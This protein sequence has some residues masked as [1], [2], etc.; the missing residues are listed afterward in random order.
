MIPTSAELTLLR[1]HPQETQ[2]W[3]SIYQPI[4]ILSVQL[5]NATGTPGDR[6]IPYDNIFEGWYTS[7]ESG[8]TMYVGTTPGAKD[9][10]RV[11]VRSATDSTITVAENS[12]IN[13]RDD[14]FLSV[15][16]F[17]EIDAVYPRITA[18]GTDTYWYK[19]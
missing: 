7:V 4:T 5:N 17:W 16:R 14:L 2:L 12:D 8:M 9:V 3:M 6:V 10:G 18:T 19:D 1:S 15:V 11:R 13:W